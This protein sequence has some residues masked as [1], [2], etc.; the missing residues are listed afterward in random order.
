[1]ACVRTSYVWKWILIVFS[2]LLFLNSF[3]ANL[4]EHYL[5]TSI[6]GYV[7]SIR[8]SKNNNQMVTIMRRGLKTEIVNYDDQPFVIGEKIHVKGHFF[9]TDVNQDSLMFDQL[10]NFEAETIMHSGYVSYVI[11]FKDLVDKFIMS[12]FD[13]TNVIDNY[14]LGLTLNKG[15][16]VS[17]EDMKKSGVYHL[18]IISGFHINLI[19]LFI[20]FM[21]RKLNIY[22]ELKNSILIAAFGIYM[23]VCDFSISIYRAC[24]SNIIVYGSRMIKRPI[25]RIYAT[26]ITAFILF[27]VNPYLWL[28]LGFQ[29]SYV[30]T[31]LIIF[32]VHKLAKQNVLTTFIVN[33]YACMASAI[34]FTFNEMTFTLTSAITTFIFNAIVSF[35]LIPLSFIKLF[36]EIFNRYTPLIDFVYIHIISKCEH[37]I[38]IIADHSNWIY[39]ENYIWFFAFLMIACMIVIYYWIAKNGIIKS[40]T[41]G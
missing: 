19:E 33:I 5:S 27:I 41:K 3:H 28:N 13:E 35:V 2:S 4:E 26:I 36:C 34:I 1:M 37:Y 17:D 38:S 14:I 10:N 24:I 31:F 16:M 7:S 30:L 40:K 29:L 39:I 20:I 18:F 22:I 12:H 21:M 15:E 25:N 9:E 32:V 6:D 8:Y 23:F 11:F